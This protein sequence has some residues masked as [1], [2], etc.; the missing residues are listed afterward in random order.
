MSTILTPTSAFPGLLTPAANPQPTEVEPTEVPDVDA[1]APEAEAEAD[2]EATAD[3]NVATDSSTVDAAHAALESVARDADAALNVL[4]Q[5]A[6]TDLVAVFKAEVAA[7]MPE[8]IAQIVAAVKPKRGR[9]PGSKNRPKLEAAA[10]ARKGGRKPG[11]K[12][13]G[14]RKTKSR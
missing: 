11:R 9:P 12:T 1:E 7:F 13:K 2:P 6:A 5:N 3:A 4:A 8:L 10:P 14:G